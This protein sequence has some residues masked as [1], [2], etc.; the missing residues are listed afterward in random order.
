M[1]MARAGWMADIERVEGRAGDDFGETLLSA[2]KVS[3]NAAGRLR[4][5]QGN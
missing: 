1:V 3:R 4:P 5:Q 2:K